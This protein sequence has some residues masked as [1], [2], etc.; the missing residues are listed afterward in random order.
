M[1]KLVQGFKG[2]K[3][4]GSKPKPVQIVQEVIL[5]VPNVPTFQMFQ[6]LTGLTKRRKLARFDNSKNVGETKRGKLRFDRLGWPLF[7]E[8]TPSALRLATGLRACVCFPPEQIHSSGRYLAG[9]GKKAPSLRICTRRARV[10]GSD[11]RGVF[12]GRRVS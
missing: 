4:Q 3:V 6:S 5:P 12:P 7:E 10:N 1:Q 2:S 9:R 8:I 11:V